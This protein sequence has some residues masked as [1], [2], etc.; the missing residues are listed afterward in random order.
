[1][2]KG[3]IVVLCLVLAASTAFAAK[4]KELKTAKQKTSYAVGYNMGY[5]LKQKLEMQSIEYDADAL[6]RGVA[7]A[8]SGGKP[9]LSEQEIRDTLM[10]LQKDLDAKRKEAMAKMKAL[11]EK[12]KAEGEKFLKENA[13]KKGVKTLPSGLQ[14]KILAEG[15]GKKPAATD[16]VTVNYRGT[17]IDGTEFD[18]SAKHGRPATFALNQVI[19]GWTEGLQLVRQGG[20]IELFIPPDLAYGERGAGSLIGPNA[21]L[22]FEVE[23]LSIGKPEKP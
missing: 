6:E 16:T 13:A 2:K 1:M 15:K 21:T 14:Y 7:D 12:N 22:I 11:G 18:S 20:K 17:L 9:A 8:F 3:F 5:G 19:K 23:L 4:K 10:A